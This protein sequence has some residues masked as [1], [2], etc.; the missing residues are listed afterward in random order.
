[1]L[2][3]ELFT[4]NS[5]SIKVLKIVYR[6]KKVSL[7]RLEQYKVN[8]KLLYALVKKRFLYFKDNFYTLT[9]NGFD[10][11]AL[12]ELKE[13]GLIK[14]GDRIGTGKEADIFIGRLKVKTEEPVNIFEEK[15]DLN[16]NVNTF[17]EIANKKTEEVQETLE[18]LTLFTEES[19]LQ[20]ETKLPSEESQQLIE[21][22]E[23]VNELKEEIK[24][25]KEELKII[26]EETNH[27]EKEKIDFD[28]LCSKKDKE[29]NNVIFEKTKE[30]E[31]RLEIKL[32]GYVRNSIDIESVNQR[33]LQFTSLTKEE[34]ENN[35]ETLFLRSKKER[36]IDVIVK[37]H[38]LGRTSFRN[39][40]NK[41]DYKEDDWFSLSIKSAELESEFL[42][43]FYNLPIP[44]FYF[45]T[46]HLVV[47][48]YLEDYYL[49]NDVE[50]TNKDKVY[51]SL[52]NFI[53]DLYKRGYVHGDFNEFNVLIN[54]REEIKVIDF[55]QSV[56]VNNLLAYEYLQRDYQ[57]I[58]DYFLRKYQYI[59]TCDELEE[60]LERMKQSD[61]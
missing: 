58:N 43:N 48:E 2:Q 27:K 25:L 47:M 45:H 56:S 35:R 53:I 32:G 17:Y 13:K 49:L 7:Q 61:E 46:N 54:E 4:L 55:P 34:I 11:I 41:R 6:S 36:V 42:K 51:N 21:F 44:K 9:L 26:E 38:R 20:E 31:E 5:D 60:I 24:G 10:A 22:A 57:T 12:N 40:K 59:I 37:F 30:E 33:H 3:R 39:V 29:I 16:G 50:I 19:D 18:K 14:L 8:L 52:C 1:M 28:M 23:E 15:Y